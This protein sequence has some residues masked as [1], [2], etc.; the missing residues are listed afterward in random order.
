MALSAGARDLLCVGSYSEPVSHSRT[1]H[2]RELQILEVDLSTGEQVVR[3]QSEGLVNPAFVA[4]H[5]SLPVLYAVSESWTAPGLV[6]SLRFDDDF[7]RL[8]DRREL[9][10]GG[11]VPSY[12]SVVGEFLTLSNYGDGSVVVYRLGPHGGLV[13]QVSF[14][15]LSGGGPDPERQDGPHTHCILGHPSNGFVYVADLGADLVMCLEL[16]DVTGVLKVRQELSVPPGLGPR[17]LAFSA[18]AMFCVEELSSTLA[19]Y[20]VEPD[21]DLVLRQRLS[22]LPADVD[23]SSFG[24]DL[25]V[26][27]SGDR[28]FASNRGHDSVVTFAGRGTT[29]QAVDWT[30]TGVVPRGL[31]LTPDGRRLLVANQESDRIDVFDVSG[32]GLAPSLQLPSATPTCLR[33]ITPRIA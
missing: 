16:D 18:Y 30:P 28:V 21:G 8:T 20:A 25:V 1:A 31:A 2:G 32:A 3:F 10:T 29:W 23:Q 9:P 24:A 13:D 33:W 27:P 12:V 11:H 15:P 5:P 22:M 17:H 14:Q 6:T 7:T 19:V 26:S 4:V